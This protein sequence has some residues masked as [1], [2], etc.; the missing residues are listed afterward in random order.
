MQTGFNNIP[1]NY[2]SACGTDQRSL[3]NEGSRSSRFKKKL[4]RVEGA[5]IAP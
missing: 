3:K 5:V 2:T 1:V 4:P